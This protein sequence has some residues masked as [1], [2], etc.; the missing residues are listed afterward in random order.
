[1]I[2]I[3]FIF[4]TRPEFLKIVEVLKVL[5]KNPFLKIHVISSNQQVKIL[6]NYIYED[7]FLYNLKLNNFKSD[8]SFISK[9]LGQLEKIYKTIRI[10]Y[11]FIQGDT[12]T[13]F[14]TSI[15]GFQKKIPIIHLEAGLR[16][17]DLENPF[18]EEYIRQCISK[19]AKI[20]LAQTKLSKQNLI[21]EGIK[22]KIY[23][24]GNPGIDHMLKNLNLKNIKKSNH[25]KKIL[26]TMH[27][28]ESL[29]GSL[30]LFLIN[31]SNFL[32]K[33]NDYNVLW[34]IHTNPNIIQHVNSSKNLFAKSKIIFCKP[35]KYQEFLK[36]LSESEFVITDSGG[37]QEEA[38]YIGKPLLIARDKTERK[39]I[40]TLE[41]GKIIKGNGEDLEKSFN[42]FKNN[43]IDFNKTKEWRKIQGMGNSSSKID[44][45]F[46]KIF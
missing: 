26:V 32:M 46:K 6:K 12:N 30:K 33:N 23:V 24:V 38:A 8:A 15:F 3:C 21:D 2:N 37:V 10:D 18:P 28:R 34:P 14:A 41:I 1:M 29:G 39:E 20:H 31:L 45:L 43:K 5:K 27:R 44:R 40:V 13:A 9:L 22:N 16:T 25:S 17:Y 19:T 36:Q 11:L 7:L 35:L 42:Y 4:G